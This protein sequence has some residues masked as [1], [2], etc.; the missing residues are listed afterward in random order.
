MLVL[1]ALFAALVLAAPAAATA[2][3]PPDEQFT[4]VVGEV[5]HTPEPVLASD[6]HIH[7]AYE[8]LVINRPV[9]EYGFV[10]AAASMKRIQVLDERGKVLLSLSGKK[11][12]DLTDRFGAPEPGTKLEPGQSGFVALD[13]I[14]P[15]G[16]KVPR[17]LTHRM[18]IALHPDQGVEA[19]TYMT[20]PSAVSS[21]Q[22]I[23]L[24]PPLRGS[25]WA[26]NDGCCATL[27]SHRRG[28]LP[29]DGAIAVGGRFS[30]D[31][32]QIQ[33]DGRVIST[34]PKTTSDW[35]VFPYFGAPVY[36]MASGTVV[37]VVNDVPETP[38]G[39]LP[40]TT[41]AAAAGNQ[42]IVKIAPG[43][44]THYSF[45]KT[46]SVLVHPGQRVKTGQP[47]AAIGSQRLHQRPPASRRPARRAAT[48]R[49]RRPAVPPQ[50]LHRLRDADQLQRRLR[51]QGRQDSSRTARRPP[52]GD[53]ARR[54]GDELPLA[55][56][57]RTSEERTIAI[58]AAP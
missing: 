40:P 9:L 47:I 30:I 7:L 16:A 24:A 41:A 10:N 58:T 49:R 42:L 33:P 44:Y 34:P 17:H 3:A 53:A 13:V 29:I 37:S 15:K 45:L 57:P 35:D 48:L 26:L 2:A 22:A 50:P 32:T 27:T 8:L 11:L 18:S 1:L 46:G 28:V 36:A 4:P 52:Q 23:V 56:A 20:G 31:F 51:R 55:A 19:T 25:G 54:T 5:I 12:A 43:L 6:G 14:L 38:L 21:H 39:T